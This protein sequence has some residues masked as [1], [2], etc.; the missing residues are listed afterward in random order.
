MVKMFVKDENGITSW[1]N[2][3]Y[4]SLLKAFCLVQIG[5]LIMFMLLSIVVSLIFQAF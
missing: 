3:S 5:I 2:V 4:W 1:V